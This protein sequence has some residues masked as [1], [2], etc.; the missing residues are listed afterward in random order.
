VH[1]ELAERVFAVLRNGEPDA[2]RAFLD[3]R[4]TWELPGRSSLAGVHTGADAIVALLARLTELR[5]VRD[6]AYDVMTS[7]HHATLTTRLVGDGLD[8]DHAIVVVARDGVLDRA[9]HYLFDAYAFDRHFA[10]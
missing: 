10:H 3:D 7:E 9:F 5:P 6:D 2:A 8:S 4:S 1:G